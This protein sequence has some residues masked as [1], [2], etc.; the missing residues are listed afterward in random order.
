MVLEV[1][2]VLPLQEVS[3][4]KGHRRCLDTVTALFPDLGAVYLGVFI[5][6]CTYNVGTF[7]HVL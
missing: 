1:T 6:L 2:I 4:G 3:E 7:L 5:K